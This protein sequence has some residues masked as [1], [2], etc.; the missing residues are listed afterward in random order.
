MTTSSATSRP[1]SRRK[2]MAGTAGAALAAKPAP[3]AVFA[4]TRAPLRLGNLNSF[5]GA[6]AYAAENNLHGMNLYLDSV[7]GTIAGRK[8]EI[9]KEDDQFNPQVG[10]P[11]G[12]EL[13]ESDKVDLVGGVQASNVALAW[14]N[15]IKV[16]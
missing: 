10:L 7:G 9:I 12:K 2:F 13:V 4:Q 5:T 14:L 1:I 6:I 8:V 16:Q 15:L 3:P 11:K